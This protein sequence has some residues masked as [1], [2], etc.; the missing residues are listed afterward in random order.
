[1]DERDE[2][3]RADERCRANAQ[4]IFESRRVGLLQGH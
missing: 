2:S 4:A 1:L 3:E